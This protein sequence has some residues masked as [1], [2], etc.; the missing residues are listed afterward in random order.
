MVD[1]LTTNGGSDTLALCGALNSPLVPELSLLLNKVPLGAVMVAVVKFAVLDS[2]ELSSMSLW[3]HL[4]VLDRLDSA[5]VVILVDFL[6]YRS[7]DL[8]MLMRL[9]GLVGNCRSNSLVDC[10]VVMTR[11]VGEI[12][13]GCLDFVHLDICDCNLVDVLSV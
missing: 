11:T 4:S 8:L 1:V 7:V 2:T 3:K 12:S 6:V 10:G 9:D 13:E 5:V